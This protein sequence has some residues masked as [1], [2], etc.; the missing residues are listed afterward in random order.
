[1]SLFS[2]ILKKAGSNIRR[3]LPTIASIA[4]PGVG[5][6]VAGGMLEGASTRSSSPA[7]LTSTAPASREV[8]NIPVPGI[9]GAVARAIPGG[10]TGYVSSKKMKP[11]KL[12][13][14]PIPHG[15]HEKMSP[16]GVIYLVKSRRRRGITY[17]DL[18]TYRR[19]HRTL[20]TYAK[21]YK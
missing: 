4:I 3:A 11:G 16:Q 21:K 12:T 13:G 18:A 7:R 19:V 9:G 1:M 6:V 15:Y 20:K 5:G 14:N 2:T 10:K 17:R 8:P